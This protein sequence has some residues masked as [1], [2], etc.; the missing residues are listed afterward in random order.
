MF[1]H[2]Q[3]VKPY[4]ARHKG[5]PTLDLF[6]AHSQSRLI[7]KGHRSETGI[8]KRNEKYRPLFMG[9]TGRPR[10]T[11]SPPRGPNCLALLRPPVDSAA[12]I[13]QRNRGRRR[14]GSNTRRW[15]SVRD[16]VSALSGR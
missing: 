11:P 5:S 7:R 8:E 14:R 6:P 16:I 9:K 3:P 2:I 13:V 15:S 1:I 4:W 10:P 12:A